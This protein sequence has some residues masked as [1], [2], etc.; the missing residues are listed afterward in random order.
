[1]NGG[2]FSR[3]EIESKIEIQREKRK[4]IFPGK[5]ALRG[6]FAPSTAVFFLLAPPIRGFATLHLDGTHSDNFETAATRTTFL[7]SRASEFLPTGNLVE[8]YLQQLR[9]VTPLVQ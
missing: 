3:I 5:D 9:C 6:A 7:I 2:F 1:M 8:V 4:G